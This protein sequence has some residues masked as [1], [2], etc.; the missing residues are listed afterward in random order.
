MVV[1]A[2]DESWGIPVGTEVYTADG[3]CLGSVV[4]GDTYELVVERGWFFIHDYQIRLSEV[5]R[6]EDGKL[7]LRLTKAD[8]EQQRQETG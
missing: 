6:F 2:L 8:A 4:E 3:E 5:D 7:V 1:T